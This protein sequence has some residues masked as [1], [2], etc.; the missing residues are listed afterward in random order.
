MKTIAPALLAHYRSGTATVCA[1]WKVTLQDG[2]VLGFTSH[3][4]DLAIG[5]TTYLART[6]LLPS[7]FES[8]T[9][10]AVDNLEAAGFLDSDAISAADL[11]AGRWDFALVEVFLANWSNVSQGTDTLMRGRL[12]EV[13]LDRGQFRAELRGLANAYAQTIG[14]VYQPTCR[15]NLGDARCGVN[16]APWTV[17]GTL[18]SVS[19]DGLVLFDAARTEPGPA[20]PKAITAI[21]QAAS[22]QVTAAAH[23]FSVGQIVYIAGVSGMVEINGQWH[24][25]KTVVNANS[26]TLALDTSAFGAYAGGGTA[27]PSGDAGHFGYGKITMTSGASAGLSGE[28]KVYSPGTITLQMQFAAGVAAGDGYSLVA[29]C[30]KRFTEDCVSRFNNYPNFRG[31]PHL[32]GMDKVLMRGGA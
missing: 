11:A 31:E 2:A 7:T 17:A 19:A 28:V 30:G 9:R 1:C 25:V 10:L 32:P 22:A 20:A 12:G 13:S 27:A 3:D 18:G 16:L 24:Q 29:G 21:T 8:Q 5:G 6:G 4:R 15:A 26:F 14:A 23:G